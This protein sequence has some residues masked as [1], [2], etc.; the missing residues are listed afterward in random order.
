MNQNEMNQHEYN[1]SKYDDMLDLPHPV[2]RKHPRMSI[3]NR[4]AQFAPF[5]ALTGYEEAVNETARLTDQKIELDENNKQILDEKLQIIQKYVSDH[6]ISDQK[7]PDQKTSDQ[8]L[9]DQKNAQGFSMPEI[10]ITY[11][12]ADDKKSGGAYVTVHGIF[13]KIDIYDHTVVLEDRSRYKIEDIIDL[14]CDLFRTLDY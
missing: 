7:I 1:S 8:K 3:R 11:F 12:K 9:S 5:A 13:H 6:K 2:S 10:A 4:S 14:E